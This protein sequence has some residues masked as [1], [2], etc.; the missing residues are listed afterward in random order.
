MPRETRRR[1]TPGGLA[2]TTPA[3]LSKPAWFE[4]VKRVC[5]DAGAP[6]SS[7]EIEAAMSDLSVEYGDPAWDWTG[8]GAAI[9]ARDA[10][11]EG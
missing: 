3:D 9:F 8:A 7:A 11:I 2:D 1:W 5:R 4:A 6:V 10:L